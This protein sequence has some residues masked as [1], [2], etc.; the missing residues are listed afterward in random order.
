MIFSTLDPEKIRI[1]DKH[2]GSATLTCSYSPLVVDAGSDASRGPEPGPW[3]EVRLTAGPARQHGIRGQAGKH[4]RWVYCTSIT[5]RNM[6]RSPTKDVV[7]ME[8][9]LDHRLQSAHVTPVHLL[10][11]IWFTPPDPNPAPFSIV[12]EPGGLAENF[13]AKFLD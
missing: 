2:P 4:P 7:F 9:P 5:K 13:V 3:G 11:T 12:S 10:T 6:Y 8:T 1:W